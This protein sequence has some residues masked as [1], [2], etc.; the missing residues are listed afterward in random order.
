MNAQ[1]SPHRLGLLMLPGFS[2]T[3]LALL[4]DP[5]RLANRIAGYN[6][7]SWTLLSESGEFVVSSA[8][9]YFPAQAPLAG[10]HSFADLVLLS[11]PGAGFTTPAT[12]H[13]CLRKLHH[14]GTR[15]V[16]VGEGRRHLAQASIVPEATP[17]GESAVLATDMDLFGFALDLIRNLPGPRIARRVEA[18]MGPSDPAPESVQPP[19]PDPVRLP[20]SV[21][22]A[23]AIFAHHLAT[24][25][26]IR[27]VAARLDLSPRQLERR[28][29]QTMGMGPAE[30]Y[31]D[32]R[33]T[34]ARQLVLHSPD[35]ISGIARAVGYASSSNLS[36]HYRRQFGLTPSQ[37]RRKAGLTGPVTP[38]DPGLSAHPALL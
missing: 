30:Y 3:A 35:T 20:D 28:F 5:L 25:L 37:H 22:R 6:A 26:T 9:G 16:T 10:A 18:L 7:F 2:T 21:S 34:R 36:L 12:A 4:V 19:E 14:S 8:N 32:M 24:P 27:D 11:S 13:R 38:R 31:R 17:H 1:P 23:V 33:L 29:A 15:L